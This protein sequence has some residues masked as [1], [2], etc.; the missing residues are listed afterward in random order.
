MSSKEYTK[1][2]KYIKYKTKYI[3][4]KKQVNMNGGAD[5]FGENKICL[6]KDL[7]KLN[8]ELMLLTTGLY[9]TSLP[10]TSFK[11]FLYFSIVATISLPFLE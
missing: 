3:Q 7:D 10:K 2:E 9:L 5:P 11:S 8:L 4:L 1:Y 6:Y